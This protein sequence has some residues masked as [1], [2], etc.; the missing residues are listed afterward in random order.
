M[1]SPGEMRYSARADTAGKVIE[2]P[3]ER[4]SLVKAGDVL[5]ELDSA[6]QRA[7]L[8]EAEASLEFS[9]A[10]YDEKRLDV[11]SSQ[12]ANLVAPRPGRSWPILSRLVSR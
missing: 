8:A 10:Q 3:V 6:E 4:G 7:T 2:A 1:T 5:V 9:R 11:M 12:A